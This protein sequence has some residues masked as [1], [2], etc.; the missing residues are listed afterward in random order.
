MWWN[1]WCAWALTLGCVSRADQAEA[2][3][4]DDCADLTIWGLFWVI[5]WYDQGWPD[6]YVYTVYD[7]IFG[8]FPAKNTRGGQLRP[9]M[10][11]FF[12]CSL[13]YSPPNWQAPNFTS[14]DIFILCKIRSLPIWGC[15]LNLLW[16]AGHFLP[17]ILHTRSPTAPIWNI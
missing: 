9:K 1:L 17:Q 7:R 2:D 6:P 8:D 12:T 13:A 4:H 14:M 5:E 16:R 3:A 11:K 10:G 15:V